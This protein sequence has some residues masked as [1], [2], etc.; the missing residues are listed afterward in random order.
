VPDSTL[1]RLAIASLLGVAPAAAAAEDVLGLDLDKLVSLKV[2][3]SSREL[4]PLESAT[5]PMTVI[6]AED[7]ERQ[8]LR[9]LKEVLERSAGF[10]ITPKQAYDIVAARGINRNMN[11]LFLIDGHVHNIANVYGM[12]QQ[13]L[14]PTLDKIERIEIVRGPGSTLWGS[15]AAAGII[16][17][18]TKDGALLDSGRQ[19]A[20]SGRASVEY[21]QRDG[22]QSANLLW[23]KSFANGGDLLASLTWMK[24]NGDILPFYRARAN[25]PV[26]DTTGNGLYNWNDSHELFLKGRWNGFTLTFYDTAL[27]W[28]QN[29]NYT[30]TSYLDRTWKQTSLNLNHLAQF[31]S[32]WSLESR[33]WFDQTKL[34]GQAVYPE[35]GSGGEAILRLARPDSRLLLG[36]RYAWRA[37]GPDRSSTNNF[38]NLPEIHDNTVSLFGEIEY[39]DFKPWILTAGGRLE[40]NTPRSNE[41][42]FMPRLAVVRPLADRWTVKLLH[43]TGIVRPGYIYRG[44]ELANPDPVDG[45]YWLG[46][47]KAQQ[48]IS[49]DLQLV[50]QGPTTQAMLTVSR[51]RFSNYII[52]ANYGTLTPSGSAVPP[53]QT[54][55]FAY[56]NL[57]R[58]T[59][60][61]LE[62][63]WRQRLNR[64]IDLYGNYAYTRARRGEAVQQTLLGAVAFGPNTIFDG[65]GNMVGTPRHLAN[66]GANFR[67]PGAI[68]VNLNL[69]MQDGADVLW[70]TSPI[71]YRTLGPD[72]FADFAATWRPPAGRGL[73]VRFYGRNLFD[74]KAILP[75]SQVLYQPEGRAF[76]IE[77]GYG[78]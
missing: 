71:T 29:A 12:D 26:L 17:I 48:V 31:A 76:G 46:A 64:G 60:R 41:T 21:Q 47:K 6:T 28:A 43:N 15:D 3:T 9:T 7:I 67:L 5:S 74:R 49:D 78:F 10:S 35:T 1:L 13:H 4:T 73:D 44:H 65:A 75:G 37:I 45:G 72:V 16:H 57:D 59:T 63:E 2:V 51:T 39:L 69:R 14:Y 70:K 20:G 19:A 53:G 36:G 32:G 25:G 61:G 50:Y 77:L 56:L 18:I 42:L 55:R 52:S 62:L 33:L 40:Y 54:W 34:T 11:I 30:R 58:L 24:S 38:S 66:L 22:R 68:D 27:H 8:G 23:G